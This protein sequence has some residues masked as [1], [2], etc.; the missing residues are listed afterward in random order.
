MQGARFAGQWVAVVDEL[1]AWEMGRLT[2]NAGFHMITYE[3][4]MSIVKVLSSAVRVIFN[5]RNVVVVD[6]QQEAP[7]FY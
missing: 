4:L 3:R 7:R 5:A 2:N 1:K 6:W